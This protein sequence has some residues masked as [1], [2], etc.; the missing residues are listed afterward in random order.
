[1]RRYIHSMCGRPPQSPAPCLD[2]VLASIDAPHKSSSMWVAADLFWAAIYHLRAAQAAR[3]TVSQSVGQ[4]VSQLVAESMIQSVQLLQFCYNF[5]LSAAGHF[6]NFFLCCEGCSQNCWLKVKY[7][8]ESG[9]VV[10]D[11]CVCRFV[12]NCPLLSLSKSISL[13][14][15]I[16]L[17]LSFLSAVLHFN[18]SYKKL[19]AIIPRSI[20]APKCM[21]TCGLK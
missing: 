20:P 18:W 14:L 1:M 16:C 9:K 19:Y 8:K 17:A 6:N 13:S 5:A 11:I 21:L 4:S 12:D 7:L 15:S 3:Q 2:G 10:L